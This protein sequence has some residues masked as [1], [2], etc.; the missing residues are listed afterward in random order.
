MHFN[1]K[2]L[3]ISNSH[4]FVWWDHGFDKFRRGNRGRADGVCPSQHKFTCRT[5]FI[6]WRV[7]IMKSKKKEKGRSLW[8]KYIRLIR[9]WTEGVFFYQHWQ[10]LDLKTH[11]ERFSTL[12]E[13]LVYSFLPEMTQSNTIVHRQLR[14][15]NTSNAD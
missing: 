5:S 2:L 7:V 3:L 4:R 9:R 10:K 1:P 14:G 8:I 6:S 12:Q 11:N 13:M 15:K